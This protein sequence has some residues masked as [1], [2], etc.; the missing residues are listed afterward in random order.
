[1][2]IKLLYTLIVVCILSCQK[3]REVT[4]PLVQYIPIKAAL[5]VKINNLT[6]LKSELK[7]NEFL[8]PLHSIGNYD[9]ILGRIRA[10][11]FIQS[12]TSGILAFT[13]I[14]SL[15]SEFIYVSNKPMSFI[16]PDKSESPTIEAVTFKGRSYNRFEIDQSTF[17][18]I[19]LDA[20]IMLGSSLN[21]MDE[22]IENINNYEID[23]I[24]NTLFETSNT[25]KSAS[26]YINLGQSEWMDNYILNKDATIQFS[27]FADWVTFDIEPSQDYLQL[28]GIS[29]SQDST[30][31]LLALFKNTRP[32]V[33]SI[34]MKMPANTDALVSF[35]FDNYDVFA[36]N[37]KAYLEA[38]YIKDSVFSTVEEIGIIFIENKK[39]VVLGTYGAESITQF[40]EGKSSN[41]EV[42]MGHETFELLSN[43]FL[44][45]YFNPL[46]KEFKANYYTILENTFVFSEELEVLQ[47]IIRD[48]N[49]GTT[50]DKSILYETSRSVLA[51]ES[52]IVFMANAQGMKAILKMHCTSEMLNDFNKTEASNYI[53]AGQVVTDANFYHTNLV[54]QK[55]YKEKE[56]N[57]ISA[58]FKVELDSDLA[59]DPQFVTNHRTNKKEIV[60][61]DVDNHLYLI[62]TE[63]KILWKKQLEGKIQGKISQVDLYKNGRLQLAFTTGNEFLILDRNGKEVAPFKMSFPGGN[64]NELAVFDY[65]GKKDYRFVITQGS[66]VFMY[67]SKGKTVKGFKLKDTDSPVIFA[68]KHLKIG[69]RDYLVFMLENGDLKILN[70]VGNSRVKVAEKID[71]SSNPTYLYKDN[72]IVTD[73]KGTLYSIDT[74]GNITKTKLN[75]SED[76]GLAATSK[77]LVSNNENILSIKGKNVTL[78]LGVYTHPAIFYVHDK[79]YISVTDIQSQKVYLFD[80]NAEPIQNFPVYGYSL[81]DLEDIDNDRKIE[82]VCKDQENALVLYKIN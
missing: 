18:S 8:K 10:L 72:F 26:I 63:G 45:E 41:N 58:L 40:L 15:K 82:F 52:S 9:H 11:E 74:K 2:R 65:E 42:Y 24:L 19:E 7:N 57:T 14:D 75:Y 70:R 3:Q 25:D 79:I 56:S 55:K 16:N 32:V 21:L 17:F 43:E 81:I 23:P 36:Q 44:Y 69:N 29:I 77:T 4:T 59:T 67:N 22:T 12:D 46:L 6:N 71:F 38:A 5:I 34:G 49:S 73:K 39:A 64:L 62:S 50:F 33:G 61:Q 48:N 51:D 13:E 30:K 66:K 68:P 1:M 76:H 20:Q 53:F 35:S 37:Q 47:G 80:S 28:N 54:I 31:N 27:G 60:V 78:D